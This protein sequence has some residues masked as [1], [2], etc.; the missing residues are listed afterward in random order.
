MSTTTTAT[1][2]GMDS[3]SMENIL[4]E[5]IQSTDLE[6]SL[7]DFAE[8]ARFAGYDTRVIAAEIMRLAGDKATFKSDGIFIC[9]LVALRGTAW[10]ES[11]TNVNSKKAIRGGALNRAKALIEKYKMVDK[12]GNTSTR[13]E[14]GK[15]YPLLSP[16]RMVSA[17]GPLMAAVI[18]KLNGA[19]LFKPVVTVNNLPA[20]YHTPTAPSYM[21]GDDWKQYEAAWKAWSELFSKQIKGTYK[22]SIVDAMRN[23]TIWQ[24]QRDVVATFDKA[25]VRA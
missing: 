3:A 11:L 20:I 4:K 8:E 21:N 22:Q 16:G 24:T 23:D 19:N 13:T 15:Q 25:G 6:S 5:I 7:R 17:M 18:V 1:T 14:N 12:I 2:F 9:F 10:K